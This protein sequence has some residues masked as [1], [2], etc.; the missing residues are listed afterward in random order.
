MNATHAFDDAHGAHGTDDNVLLPDNP[1]TDADAALDD[2]LA[3][4][5]LDAQRPADENAFLDALYTTRRY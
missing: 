4:I 3:M 1:A 5:M 2:E